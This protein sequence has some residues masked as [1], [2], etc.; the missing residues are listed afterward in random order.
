MVAFLICSIA[1]EEAP[2]ST[3]IKF[4]TLVLGRW[5]YATHPNMRGGSMRVVGRE[6]EADR[7]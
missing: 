6:I 7:C 4:G 1:Q 5:T 3:C 2:K